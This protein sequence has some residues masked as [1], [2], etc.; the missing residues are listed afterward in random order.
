MWSIYLLDI[1]RVTD[2]YLFEK[3][4]QTRLNFETVNSMEEFDERF[5]VFHCIYMF[6]FDYYKN[7]N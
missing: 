6:G 2:I 7:C 1:K 4:Y 3:V 5:Y